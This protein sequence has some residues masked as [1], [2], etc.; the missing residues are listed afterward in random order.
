MREGMPANA[1]RHDPKSPGGPALFAGLRLRPG[2][3]RPSRRSAQA[4]CRCGFRQ[5]S[6]IHSQPLRPVRV[7][8]KAGESSIRRQRT[9]SGVVHV[10][11]KFA[12]AVEAPGLRFS[13]RRWRSKG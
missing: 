4:A 9:P 11:E 2:R 7:S 13:H 1:S 12:V 3:L 10:Y 5:R 6:F 8:D